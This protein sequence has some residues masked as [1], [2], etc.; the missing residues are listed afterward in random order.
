MDS[1]QHQKTRRYAEIV[2]A[3]REVF[4]SEG[5][6]AANI[7]KIAATASVSKQSVYKAFGGKRALFVTVLSAMVD[8]AGDAVSEQID[9]AQASGDLAADLLS[10]ARGQLQL[11]M[12]PELMR[13]RRT[14]IA[15]AERFPELAETFYER[16]AGR[17]I[18]ALEDLFTRLTDEDV[19]I[20]DP[21]A[22]AARFNWLVM[23]EPV[24]RAMLLGLR[25]APNREQI[26]WWASQAVE[27][28]MA[29]YSRRPE[30]AGALR[31]SNAVLGEEGA[32]R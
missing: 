22:A 32:P 30:F 2:G 8:E 1:D 15:E 20:A 11:V 24:N 26:D 29:I 5:F 3:A 7:D 17:I 31:V 25:Q 9:R 10:L 19:V 21:A 18:S 14:V 12:T 28:F 27:A 4:L 23:A 16:G 6:A 13:L